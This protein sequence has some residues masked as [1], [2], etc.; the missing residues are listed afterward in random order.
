MDVLNRDEL[1][2]RLARVLSKGLRAEMKKLLDLLG[3][4]PD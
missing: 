1:E 4:P 3:D 2:R